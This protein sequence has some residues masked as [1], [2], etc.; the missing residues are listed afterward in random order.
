MAGKRNSGKMLAYM[1][2]STPHLH[3]I[4]PNCG[5]A[6][7]SEDLCRICQ[8]RLIAAEEQKKAAKAQRK[9]AE[10]E[11]RYWEVKAEEERKT[12]IQRRKRTSYRLYQPPAPIP[13]P[14]P[15]NRVCTKCGYPNNGRA[16]RCAECGK[17]L[18]AR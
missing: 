15:A 12:G 10:A 4:C 17:Q 13:P 18:S 3:H 11:K 6:S 9:A 16:T 7:N 1:S 2:G 5:G 8:T 14:K